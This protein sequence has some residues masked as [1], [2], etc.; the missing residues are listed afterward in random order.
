MEKGYIGPAAALRKLKA[1]RGMP[2][3][4]YLYGATGYGKTELVRQFLSGQSY[5]WLSCGDLPW[6]DGAVLSQGPGTAAGKQPRRVVVIDGLHQLKGEEQRQ[7]I[8]DWARRQ[9]LWLILISR[10][11]IPPWLMP[12]YIKDG[13]IV[14]TEE[15]LRL[16]QAEIA[17][18][19]KACGI[20][21]T[22]EDARHLERTSE[23]NA[24]AIR[25]AALKLKEWKTLGAAMYE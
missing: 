2:Q 10:S 9:D 4:V 25:H 20:A 16:G 5:T 15:D 18:Y 6:E 24:Y 17:G 7:K 8:T 3:T 19:L 21:C 14:I 22:E 1:A 13:F 12:S 23:G 11:P